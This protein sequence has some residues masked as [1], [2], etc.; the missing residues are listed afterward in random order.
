MT[1]TTPTEVQAPAT[2][3]IEIYQTVE[4]YMVESLRDTSQLPSQEE[5]LAAVN[6]IDQRVRNSEAV[7]ALKEL[8]RRVILVAQSVDREY[9]VGRFLDRIS[10][11]HEGLCTF[12]LDLV[13]KPSANTEAIIAAVQQEIGGE[14]Y[15]KPLRR[16]EGLGASVPTSPQ[17]QTVERPT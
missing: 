8:A 12:R 16:I 13:P 14:E 3:A 9:G 10:I 5:T 4:E 7:V 15:D 1:Q 17:E 11:V 2:P 6:A